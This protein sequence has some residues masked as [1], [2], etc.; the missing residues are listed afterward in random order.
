MSMFHVVII[1]VNVDRSSSYLRYVGN[2]KAMAWC[3]PTLHTEIFASKKFRYL[4]FT[5]LISYFYLAS[6]SQWGK[7][8]AD[9]F[10]TFEH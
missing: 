6:K 1:K 8:A 3:I 7:L 4:A 9:I 2:M 5:K 10:A